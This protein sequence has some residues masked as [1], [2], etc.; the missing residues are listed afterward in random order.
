MPAASFLND[1]LQALAIK[2]RRLIGQWDNA[3]LDVAPTVAIPS[4]EDELD[5]LVSSRGEASGTALA[6]SILARWQG[7]D[8]EGQRDFLTIL[9]RDFGPDRARLDVAI[10]RYRQD[11]SA[12]ALTAL[13]HAAEPRR[14]ELL[15][16]LNL[17]SGGTA[18]LVKMREVLLKAMADDPELKAVDADF[19][20]LFTS[21]FNRGFLILKPIDWT[22]PA[23][24]LEKIIQYEAVHDIGGWDELRRR[25]QPSDRRCFAFFHPQLNDEPL[26]FVEVALTSDIP[27]RISDVLT[28][29]RQKVRPDEARTAVFYSISNCQTGL[30]GVSFGNFLIKQVVDDLRR[31][32]P[33]LETFVTLSPV[34]GLARWLAAERASPSVLD[35]ELLGQLD[36]LDIANWQNDPVERAALAPALSAATA[37]YFLRARSNGRLPDPVGRFHLGNG[38]RLH[39]INALADL[40]PRGLRE[41]HGM[42]VNYLY[43]LDEIGSN[44]EAFAVQ[45]KTVASDAVQVLLPDPRPTSTQEEVAAERA[46]A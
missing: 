14:Q 34:P 25:L 28:E 32:L 12:A 43:K 4:L 37:A 13:S 23:N 7:L 36:G 31:E 1:M 39:Q 18:T 21:W 35:D 24:I 22:T 17:A 45:D 20:H 38:A 27:Q 16:R 10:E 8:K 46:I 5:A 2:G 41:A 6:Q 29:N 15:R 26:I 3:A 9:N 44:H 19:L 11:R 30:R 33:N 40:S 42:M